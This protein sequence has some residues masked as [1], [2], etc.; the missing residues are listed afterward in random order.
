MAGIG[1]HHGNY[2]PGDAL[3]AA[4]GE[5]RAAGSVAALPVPPPG[6]HPRPSSSP[7]QRP[8]PQRGHANAPRDALV[9]DRYFGVLLLT[10]ADLFVLSLVFAD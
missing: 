8:A 5:P 9:R 2:F 4:T 3:S 1:Q 10:D 7:H 6:H